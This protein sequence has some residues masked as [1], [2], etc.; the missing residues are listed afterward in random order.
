MRRLALALLVASVAYAGPDTDPWE[1]VNVQRDHKKPV[2]FN[3]EAYAE[4]GVQTTFVDAGAGRVGT[5]SV[6]SDAGV[7]GN[8]A[9]TG[10]VAITGTLSSASAA[11]TLLA[12]TSDAGI[13]G[14]ASVGGALAVT[15]VS[16][17]GT[18]KFDTLDAGVVNVVN[19]AR[20]GGSIL[21]AE[22]ISV[23]HCTLNAASPAVCTDTVAASTVLCVCA[24]VGTTA[25]I[26]AMNCAVSVSSTTLTITAANAANAEVN[27]ICF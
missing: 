18:G 24:P 7:A 19:Q 2:R 20:I 4:M 23:G 17:G 27:W 25:A 14:N 9:V 1:S 12:V 10:T 26:A 3:R 21:V 16:S 6:T 13:G 22:G 11:P 8:F 5:L 15:G